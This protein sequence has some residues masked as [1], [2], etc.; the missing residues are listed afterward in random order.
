MASA[1]HQVTIEV[2]GHKPLLINH[3]DSSNYKAD[4]L[5]RNFTFLSTCE[6]MREWMIGSISGKTNTILLNSL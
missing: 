6:P 5:E 4:I 1:D 3:P 2:P